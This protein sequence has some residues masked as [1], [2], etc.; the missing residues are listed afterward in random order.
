MFRNFVSTILII[1]A[2]FGMGVF[3]V[4][5]NSTV[6]TE[7][8]SIFFSPNGGA[9]AAVVVELNDAKKSL[10]IAAYT[11]THPDISLAIIRAHERGVKVRVIVDPTLAGASY[12][13]ATPLMNAGI[14][15]L[16]E[17]GSGL[18]HHKLAIIDGKTII[19]GSM[20]WSRAGD[21]TNSEDLVIIRDKT[22]AESYLEHFEKLLEK[23]DPFERPVAR[24]SK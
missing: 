15:V 3:V 18:L 16:V 10:S 17:R 14:P 5:S 1:A 4:Q 6:P 9:A 21:E 24:S 7:R 2:V 11:I 22:I 20:N 8:V 23:A 12:S 19:T 13:A